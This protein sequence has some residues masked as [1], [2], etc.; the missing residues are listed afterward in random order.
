LVIFLMGQESILHPAMTVQTA[1][2]IV[3]ENQ[4]THWSLERHCCQVLDLNKWAWFC[5]FDRYLPNFSDRFW[6]NMF[7]LWIFF[8]I[9]NHFFLLLNK[10]QILESKIHFKTPWKTECILLVLSF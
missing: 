9:L 4:R 5:Q 10:Q 6:K 3:I 2:L 8:L 1:I 7:T